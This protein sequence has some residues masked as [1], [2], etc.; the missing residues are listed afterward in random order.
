MGVTEPLGQ[1][2]P[3]TRIFVRKCY[4]ELEHAIWRA[5][6]AEARVTILLTGTPGI[7]KSVFGLW[8]IFKLVHFLKTARA[9]VDNLA[10]FGQG[11]NG[12]IV[13]EHVTN[14]CDTPTFY[15]IDVTAS[16][17]HSTSDRP[18]S[19]LRNKHTL[20]VKDGPCTNSDILCSALWISSPR[21]DSFQKGTEL[22]VGCTYVMPPWD[23]DELVDCW[24]SG[25]VVMRPLDAP[26]LL[27]AEAVFDALD[28]DADDDAKTEALLRRWSGEFGPVPRRVFN[29]AMAHSKLAGALADLG[30]E[31]IKALAGIATAAR[32]AGESNKLKHSHRLLLMVPSQDYTA[33]D[34]VPS[35]VAIGRKILQKQLSEDLEYAQS[36]MGK[37]AGAHLGLVFEPYAHRTLATGGTWAIRG[38]AGDNKEELLVLPSLDT[39][40]VRDNEVPALVLE[41]KKYYVPT[42]PNY[43]V[44]DSWSGVNMFQMTVSLGHPIKSGAK[45]YKALSRKGLTRLI[46]VVPKKHA[47][48]FAQQ[49]LV[50]AKGKV[51]ERGPL[52]GWNSVP[53]FVLGL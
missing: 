53:Q 39:I 3:A 44:V 22:L 35:S 47:L 12:T 36:L 41:E 43:A 25:C 26:T 38:L 23:D 11:L 51:H 28:S 45:Q 10:R 20:L 52:G 16:T 37:L 19:L 2:L 5:L 46:F 34:F 7:G 42:D 4:H 8:F 17:I 21:A 40:D 33:F 15:V 9:S 14:P 13:V 18:M 31:D 24:R 29:P 30:G 6:N 27:I 32:V 48:A 49:P 1:L 50:D